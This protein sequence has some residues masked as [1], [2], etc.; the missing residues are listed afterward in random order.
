M[1]SLNWLREGVHSSLL[2]HNQQV[3]TQAADS[4]ELPD[5]YRNI[6]CDPQTSGGLLAVVPAGRSGAV[7]D[8][9]HQAGYAAA[10]QVGVV[11]ATD[12][13]QLNWTE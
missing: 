11:A 2:R 4:E 8:A 7:L 1:V 12:K 10:A 6:M 9:L 13:H 5:M 3:L